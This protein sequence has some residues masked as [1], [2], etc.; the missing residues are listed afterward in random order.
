MTTVSFYTRQG[1]PLCD[2][3]LVVVAPIVKAMHASLEIVDIDLDLS[4]LERYNE[5]VPVIEVAGEVL[6]EGRVEGSRALR[7][8]FARA[9]RG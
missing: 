2:E 8:K 9:L 1:C 7:K 6:A 4:L 3:A 5:R